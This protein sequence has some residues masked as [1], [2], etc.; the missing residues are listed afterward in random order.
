MA[1]V[2]VG[3]GIT[4]AERLADLASA[5]LVLSWGLEEMAWIAMLICLF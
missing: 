3:V 5:L 2:T 4:L 1:S